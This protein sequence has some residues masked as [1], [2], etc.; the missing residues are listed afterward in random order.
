M[1]ES[2]EGN[3]STAIISIAVPSNAVIKIPVGVTLQSAVTVSL[4][5][6]EVNTSP[7]KVSFTSDC[8]PQ[9]FWPQSASFQALAIGSYLLWLTRNS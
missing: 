7:V 1:N 4:P 2:P 9:E 5:S 3:A 6:E 8:S